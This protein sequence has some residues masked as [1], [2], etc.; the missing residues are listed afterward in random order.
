MSFKPEYT[1]IESFKKSG[2]KP[3]FKNLLKVLQGEVPSRPT[4]FEFFLNNDLNALLCDSDVLEINDEYRKS[5]I[6]MSAYKNAGYDY[7]TLHGSDFYFPAA[8]AHKGASYSA[9]DT[10]VIQDRESFEKYNWLNPEDFDYSRLKVIGDEMPDD[11]MMIAYGP[12]GV[13][14][15]VIKLI[16]YDNLCYMSIDDPE[17][18]SDVFEGVGSRLVKYYKICGEFEKVGAMISNDDWG[19]NTQT[20]LS[21]ADMRKYVFPW[22]KKIVETIHASGK[23]AI[24][25][26]CGNLHEVYDDIVSMGYSAKHSYEDTIE[27]VEEA[28]EHLHDK[29]AVLGGIDLDYV[30]RNTPEAV[31]ERASKMLE[32][33]ASRGGYA[34]GSGNSIPCY[35]PNENY[36][37]MISAAIFG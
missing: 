1:N 28:Y 29:I 6:D 16:G 2:R 7:V 13:L 24:L 22:H 21:P 30:C 37:A 33:T 10:V 25:H 31:Y 36:L 3:D 32:R 27:P 12:G 4:L 18:L 19:F 34:L 15:N 11:M 17:L 20:M 14:E 23:P 5:R 35:T 26:S 9:N 8:D